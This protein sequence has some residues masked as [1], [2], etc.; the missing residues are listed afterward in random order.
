MSR[1]SYYRM[2]D[3]GGVAFLQGGT[4]RQ[5]RNASGGIEGSGTLQICKSVP[6]SAEVCMCKKITVRN[7]YSVIR[8]CLIFRNYS[9]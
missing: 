1:N 8:E 5:R 4:V 3:L 6:T 9:S 7:R 2:L